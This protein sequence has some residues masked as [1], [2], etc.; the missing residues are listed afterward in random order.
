MLNRTAYQ[1]LS[2]SE[3]IQLNFIPELAITFIKMGVCYAIAHL[4]RGQKN[5][6]NPIVLIQALI[7]L[8]SGVELRQIVLSIWIN[9]GDDRLPLLNKDAFL[10]ITRIMNSIIDVGFTLGIFMI[11]KSYRQQLQW[12]AREKELIREKL[13][14][15]LD[16][17][18]AQTNPHFL[19]NTM[20]NF[21][22]MA[23]ASGAI[24]LAD[25][26]VKL[27]RMMRYTLYD[28]S[29][30]L[31]PIEKEVEYINSFIQLT[32]L[33]F[34]DEEVTV[35]FKYQ[36]SVGDALIPPMIL[37]PFVEN[38]FKYGVSIN[39]Q[40]SIDLSLSIHEKTLI[41]TCTN[42]ISQNSNGGNGSSNGIGLKNVK[43]R[44]ELIYPSKH[45]L[46]IKESSKAFVV[47]LKVN[48]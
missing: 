23:Q 15:E 21:F 27:S 20:N 24:A 31:I 48:L 43:R 45:S 35:N 25:S 30:K 17:L 7:I 11:L 42:S 18:K 12:A 32:K 36:D 40:S 37:I 33:R 10:Q 29:V 26:I 1:Q 13:E 19:F 5:W 14:T 44:L 47:D 8:I 4:L 34:K 41:F 2:V 28:S 38:A 16:F 6:L 39:R 22:S 3:Q 46:L 9:I